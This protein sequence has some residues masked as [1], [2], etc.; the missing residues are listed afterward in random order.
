MRICLVNTFHYRRG[1]DCTYTFDLADLLRCK[2]HDVVHFAMKHQE[3]VDSEYGEFFA[4]HVDFGEAF[5]SRNPINRV[6]AFTRSLY[7]REARQKF[8][9]LL[10]KTRPDVVHLQNFRRH[11]TFSVV[12]AAKERGLPVVF[13]AHDYDPICPNTL[14]QA[15]VRICTACNGRYFHKAALVRCKEDSLAGSLAIALEGTFTRFRKYY[16]LIDV[17]ITP[18]AFARDRLVDCGF[19]PR[20]VRVVHNF[21]DTASYEP[22]YGGEGVIYFG[23]LVVEKGL[24]GLV[25]VAEGLPD[26][27]FMLAGD[28]PERGRLEALAEELGVKCD[29]G[30]VEFLGYVDRSRLHRIVSATMCVAMPSIWYENFPYAVLEAFALGKPVVASNIGGM[31]EM[32][33][34]GET[35]LLVEPGSVRD[36]EGAIGYLLENPDRASKMGRKARLRVEREFDGEIHYERIMEIY[37]SLV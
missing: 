22:R 24:D 8:G 21:I 14:L 27:R 28:G 3:N 35:G 11:L 31:P 5:R 15:K 30:N 36:L 19:H 16:D 9:R 4:D 2:G 33:V 20:K 25:R 18:S 29:S 12:G 10:D 23:R 34:H 37:D 7:S 13:T 17:I 1:G 6:R 32:I 26:V